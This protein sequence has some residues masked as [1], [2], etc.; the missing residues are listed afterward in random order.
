METEEIEKELREMAANQ[1]AVTDGMM[2]ATREHFMLVAAADIVAQHDHLSAYAAKLEGK[3]ASL[4]DSVDDLKQIAK[5]LRAKVAA[6]ELSRDQIKSER[7]SLADEWQRLAAKVASSETKLMK[8][9]CERDELLSLRNQL[10][11]KITNLEQ[12]A[13]NHLLNTI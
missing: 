8:A 2:Y 4:R 6:I 5:E 11:A 1:K 10:L 3:C 7:N 12:I 13:A 9:L